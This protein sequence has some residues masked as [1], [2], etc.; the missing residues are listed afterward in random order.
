MFVLFEPRLVFS[1][2]YAQVVFASLKVSYAFLK[3]FQHQVLGVLLVD[4]QELTKIVADLRRLLYSVLVEFSEESLRHH[5][6]DVCVHRALRLHS[7]LD[8]DVAHK[9][10]EVYI[11]ELHE[12]S[13]SV[14]DSNRFEAQLCVVHLR[15]AWRLALRNA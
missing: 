1:L 4:A 10:S 5:Y 13:H 11:I 7:L 3:L 12:S 14:D 2:P 9:L 15:G 8:D 6:L